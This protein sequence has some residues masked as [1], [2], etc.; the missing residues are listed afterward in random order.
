MSEDTRIE[1]EAVAKY[2]LST[3]GTVADAA[4][5]LLTGTA[6]PSS[7]EAFASINPFTST[8]ALRSQ[9]KMTRENA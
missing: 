4:R 1:I 8:D 2:T 6:S 7:A 3:F 9:E 5:T